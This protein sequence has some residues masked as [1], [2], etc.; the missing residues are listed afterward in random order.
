VQL[1][2]CELGSYTCAPRCVVLRA[3]ERIGSPRRITCARVL[4]R[5]PT[6]RA[7]D[8]AAR[9]PLCARFADASA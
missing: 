9:R 5:P 4:S 3:C 7:H 8:H 2:T 6:T 1:Q